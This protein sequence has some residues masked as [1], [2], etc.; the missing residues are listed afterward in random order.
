MA[1]KEVVGLD[2]E[3]TIALGGINKKTG[4]PNP[5]TVEGY[6]VGSRSVDTDFGPAQ[7]HVLQTAD[8]NVGVWGKTDLDRKIAAVAAGSMIRATHTGQ[9]KIP[10]RNPMHKYKVE[11]DSE[12]TIDVG[13]AADTQAPVLDQYDEDGYQKEEYTESSTDE[14]EALDEVTPTRAAPPKQLAK[15]PDAA[16]QAQAKA[17]LSKG[18]SKSVSN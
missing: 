3:S 14:D 15:T 7:L 13:S 9:V 17:L 4:K 11:V 8:G 10:G 1:F 2:T 16:R 12:D 6:Y 5:T 18:K